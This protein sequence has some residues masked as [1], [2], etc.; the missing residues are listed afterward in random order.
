M[1]YVNFGGGGGVDLGQ[2]VNW[3]NM[4]EANFARISQKFDDYNALKS[5]DSLGT[6][7]LGATFDD[8]A[9]TPIPRPLIFSWYYCCVQS[10]AFTFPHVCSMYV[11]HTHH[12]LF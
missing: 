6:V 9:P 2:C 3:S 1:I 10:F 4:D 11:S 8:P 12:H 5:E 7:G